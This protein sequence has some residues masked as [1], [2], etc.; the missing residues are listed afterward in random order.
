MTT[1]LIYWLVQM[2][3]NEN[4]S[5]PEFKYCNLLIVTPNPPAKPKQFIKPIA[6]P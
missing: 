2:G 1:W 4:G 3:I 6:R 5:M